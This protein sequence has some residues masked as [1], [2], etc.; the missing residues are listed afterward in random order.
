MSKPPPP[1]AI[2]GAVLALAAVGF[3]VL[4]ALTGLAA[5]AEAS[6]NLSITRSSAALLPEREPLSYV[7]VDGARLEP[8]LELT[9]DYGACRNEP[10]R[11]WT[12]YVAIVPLGWKPGQA[13]PAWLKCFRGCLG[14]PW[15]AGAIAGTLPLTQTLGE[16][17][18][19]P[20]ADAV[21]VLEAERKT[22]T[23]SEP[24]ASLLEPTVP[25]SRSVRLY[26]FLAVFGLLSIGSAV[27]SVISF[28]KAR[29]G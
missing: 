4:A 15:S 17:R 26:V 21:L 22:R 6:R 18:E 2:L 12:Q 5:A 8:S 16:R 23:R 9:K 19:W 27:A 25:P 3:G 13:V 14:Q 20:E 1:A 11:C 7:I 10:G 24:R 28:V 29:R